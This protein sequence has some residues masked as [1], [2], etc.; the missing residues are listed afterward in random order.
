LR[1]FEHEACAAGALNHPNI[2][3]VFDVGSHDGAPYVVSELLQ[4]ET[5][6]EAIRAG[7]LTPARAVEYAAQVADGLPAVHD[8]GIVHRDLKPENL[9][10]PAIG[11]SRSWTSAWPSW[12]TS[13]RAPAPA[14]TR[15]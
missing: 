13:G 7:A 14:K 4:G 12:P 11:G 1:R 2:L 10:S 6:R 9:S 15:R 8:K 5:L 3:V